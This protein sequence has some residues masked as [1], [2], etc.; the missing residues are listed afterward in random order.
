MNAIETEFE[1]RDAAEWHRIVAD[2]TIASVKPEAIFTACRTLD[3]MVEGRLVGDLMAMLAEIGTRFLRTR[4]S[5]NHP[6]GGVDIILSTLG[7]L[8]DAILMVEHPDAHGYSIGFFAKLDLR[9]LD[10]LR[11]SSK[12]SARES[13]VQTT[14]DGE[15]IEFPDLA[16][17]TPEEALMLDEL[18]HDVDPRKRRALALTTAGYPT[19]TDQEGGACVAS[20]LGVSRRTAETWV[21][22]MKKLALER[23]GK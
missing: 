4:V 11:R 17:A 6:N 19:Y 20:I 3:R 13:P 16:E 12:R 2:G 15:E 21:R 14:E 7:K 5:S 22:D 9:L 23:I 10:Q 1:T 8:Q 18:M